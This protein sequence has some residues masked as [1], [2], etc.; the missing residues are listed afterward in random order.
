MD[1]NGLKLCI[2]F[3]GTVSPDSI[4]CMKPSLT[5]GRQN[6]ST[7]GLSSLSTLCMHTC[8]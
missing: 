6:E 2:C 8:A 5:Y 4:N 3:V 7:S 1:A